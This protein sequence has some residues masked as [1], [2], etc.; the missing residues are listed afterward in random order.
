VSPG[1]AAESRDGPTPRWAQEQIPEFQVAVAL[2]SNLGDREEHLQAGV[3]A[4]ARLLSVE[5]VSR[6]LETPP[7]GDPDQGPFL[8]LVVLGWTRLPPREL[9]ERLLEVEQER[10]RVRSRRWGP[11]TLDADLILHGDSVLREP[12][13]ILPHPRWHL[14]PFVALPLLD[15]LPDGVDPATGEALRARVSPEVSR[16]PHM[17]RGPLPGW[18]DPPLV[19]RGNGCLAGATISKV[20]TGDPR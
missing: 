18:A 4:L 10:G 2:G 14:R 16:S 7:W 15:L 20:P 11:R 13:L 3:C 6:V 5:R 12:G 1:A 17:D 19:R 9:L 8:N